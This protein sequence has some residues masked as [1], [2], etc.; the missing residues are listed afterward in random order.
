MKICY[1]NKLLVENWKVIRQLYQ[2]YC[3]DYKRE[4]L[5]G[6]LNGC[7]LGTLS[8]KPFLNGFC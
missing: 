2:F 1:G 3:L 6:T 8:G 7:L 4:S 5:V